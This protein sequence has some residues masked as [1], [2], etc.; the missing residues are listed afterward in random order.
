VRR[1]WM[2]GWMSAIACSSGGR[3]S[4]A[5]PVSGATWEQELIPAE[6]TVA[7]DTSGTGEIITASVQLPAARYIAGLLPDGAPR[8]VLRCL[9]GRVVAFIDTDPFDGTAREESEVSAEPVRVEL[10]AAPACE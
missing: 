8:L 9:E 6:W 5:Q 2:L 3:D 4:A 7:E 10:D 1:V